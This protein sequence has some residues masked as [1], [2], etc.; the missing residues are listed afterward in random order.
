MAKGIQRIIDQLIPL[1]G[2][3]YLPYAPFPSLDQFQTIYP[4][5]EAFFQAKD[6]WDP[7]HVFMN[8]FYDDYR[9]H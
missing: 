2:S 3:Y 9:G 4:K 6:K 5:S 1:N 7:E 8:Q